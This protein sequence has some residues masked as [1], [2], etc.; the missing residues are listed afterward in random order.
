MS[1]WFHHHIAFCHTDFSPSLTEG[2]LG[3]HPTNP[4]NLPLRILSLIMSAKSF[5]PD[6]LTFTGSGDW[7]MSLFGGLSSSL[8]HVVMYVQAS[9]CRN[10]CEIIS[11]PCYLAGPLLILQNHASWLVCLLLFDIRIL[12]ALSLGLGLMKGVGVCQLDF[13]YSWWGE[14]RFILLAF[15]ILHIDMINSF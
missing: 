9:S 12:I 5:L 4:D 7:A 6:K 10:I 13:H 15:L 14:I 3:G 1:V 11:F 2:P 8:L